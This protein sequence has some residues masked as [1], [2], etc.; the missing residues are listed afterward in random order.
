MRYGL[1]AALTWALDT[2]ILSMALERLLVAA[3]RRFGRRY[4]AQA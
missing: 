4:N 2:V 1:G 3:A